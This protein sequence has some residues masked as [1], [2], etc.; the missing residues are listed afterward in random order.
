MCCCASVRVNVLEQLTG[1]LA[2]ES[3]PDGGALGD[4]GFETGP[5][6][7]HIVSPSVVVGVS[8]GVGNASHSRYGSN[9]GLHRLF[10]FWS[11]PKIIFERNIQYILVETSFRGLR[12]ECPLNE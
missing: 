7:K 2:V 8:G 9:G 6:G 12:K 11:F 5:P 4:T 10:F 3:L 1:R